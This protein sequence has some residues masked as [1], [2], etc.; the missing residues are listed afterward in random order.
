MGVG[1]CAHGGGCRELLTS[2]WCGLGS[3]D[4]QQA[5]GCVTALRDYDLVAY[6]HVCTCTRRHT[7]AFTQVS[8][9]ARA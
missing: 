1:G 3:A 8:K 4:A 5:R 2:D 9:A 6:T 7:P